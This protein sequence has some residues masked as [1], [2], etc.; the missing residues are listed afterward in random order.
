M[1]KQYCARWFT[2]D[3]SST[4]HLFMDGGKLSV[5][6]DELPH[7]LTKY[8]EFLNKGDTIAL[9]EKLGVNCIMRF[10]LDVDKIEDIDQNTIVESA[11]KI[12]QSKCNVYYCTRSKGLH[13]VY[14]KVVSCEEAIS[15]ANVIKE[16]LPPLY[17]KSIDTS[18]YKTGLR[19]IGSRKY[20]H[21]TKQFVDR[22]YAPYMNESQ[23]TMKMLKPSVVRIKT[24]ENKS[25]FFCTRCTPSSLLNTYMAKIHTN[26][27]N[28][29]ILK[30]F[31][32]KEKL[33]ID[34]ASKFC[35]NIDKE[36]NGHNIYFVLDMQTRQLYQKCFCKCNTTVGRKNGLCKNY[37]SSPVKVSLSDFNVLLQ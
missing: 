20:D 19:M 24:V 37:R 27:T 6:N 15:L 5:P 12:V 3:V 2:K 21:T 26:Y 22:Y 14:N 13:I 7:F 25:E 17:A 8:V 4:T 23:F 32:Y 35:T 28:V 33:C 9:I 31:R 34:V 29:K 1:F 16:T 18:V 36:H 11:N 10:F 30:Q